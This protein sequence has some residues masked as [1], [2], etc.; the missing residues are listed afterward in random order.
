MNKSFF[1]L[2]IFQTLLQIH[3]LGQSQTPTYFLKHLTEQEYLFQYETCLNSAFQDIGIERTD[4]LY[5]DHTYEW[6][7]STINKT[8]KKKLR[9]DISLKAKKG[10]IPITYKL[11]YSINQGSLSLFIDFYRKERKID[12]TLLLYTR[13]DSTSPI[14]VKA[15]RKKWLKELLKEAITPPVKR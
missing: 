8:I 2:C 7:V 5:N 10:A 14:F 11:S 3:L 15:L 4:S 6:L 1:V 13:M 9:V 12:K